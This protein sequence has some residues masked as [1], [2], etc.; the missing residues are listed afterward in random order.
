[1]MI[2]VRVNLGARSYNIYIG[3]GILAGLGSWVRECADGEQALLVSNRKVLS[4]YGPMVSNSLAEHV[5]G[6]YL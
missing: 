2:S 1:M 4:L 5:T 3:N 6:W